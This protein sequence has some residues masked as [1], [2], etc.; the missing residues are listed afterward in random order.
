MDLRKSQTPSPEG[1]FAL[2]HAQHVKVDRWIEAKTLTADRALL[3][4]TPTSVQALSVSAVTDREITKTLIMLTQWG[5]AQASV[6]RF[7]NSLSSFFA[8]AVRERLIQAN[9]VHPTR[10][11]RSSSPHTEMRPFSETHLEQLVDRASDCNERLAQIVLLDG[12]TGLR[13][14]E[15]RAIRVRDFIELPMPLLVVQRAEP[16]GVAAKTTKSGRTRRVPVAG[17]RP[18]PSGSARL[19]GRPH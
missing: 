4:L 1:I 16:E 2:R 6:A 17:R 12:W 11:P 19:R 14:S 9:P 3:R 5:L 7:R 10:V 15:L 18:D 13:W 8:W